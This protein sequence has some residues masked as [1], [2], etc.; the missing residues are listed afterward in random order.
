MSTHKKID[1]ICI[2]VIVIGVLLTL[3]VMNGEKIGIKEYVD[4]DAE[5]TVIDSAFTKNDETSE[6]TISDATY[7][8][9]DGDAATIKGDGAYILDGD[10]II[11]KEGKYV[12]SGNF[13]D[14]SVIIDSAKKAKVWVLLDDVSI[15]C[16]D[17]AAFIVEKADKVFI[18]L[19]KDSE[20]SITSGIDYSEKSVN[21]GIDGTIYA[22][23]DLTING[24]GKLFVKSEYKHGIVVKGDL[25]ITSGMISVDAAK[26]AIHI[27]D[28][29][30]M[31]NA[32]VLIEAGD[33]AI[34]ADKDVFIYSGTVLISKCYEGIE[35]RTVEISG[36]D[37]TIYPSDDGINASGEVV[38]TFPD[39]AGFL[40]GGGFPSGGAS[41]S[42]GEFPSGLGFPSDGEISFGGEIPFDGQFPDDMQ[43]PPAG[44]IPN[45][46]GSKSYNRFSPENEFKPDDISKD[47][48]KDSKKEDNKNKDNKNND[49]KNKEESDS[50]FP[51]VRIN[52]GTIKIINTQGVDADGI[53]SNG[54]II[55]SGGDVFI[56]LNGTGPNN[57]LDYGSENNGK[58]EITGGKVVAIGGS[59]MAEGFSETST[60]V[61]IVKTFSETVK[62]DSTLTI[63]DEDGTVYF[64]DKI[65]CGFSALSFSCSDLKIGSKLFVLVNGSGESI[66]LDGI[67]NQNINKGFGH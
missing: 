24:E 13:S 14:G 42:D 3:L 49:N 12:L 18:N 67:V 26:D 30:K 63:Q 35:A 11:A 23:D 25:A 54:D 8:N 38:R 65:P 33:D 48:E 10:L 16:N 47:K 34:T 58:L 31:E 51:T 2:A 52:G 36:G 27:N 15:N 22:K 9:L 62:K 5:G 53:D 57:A 64:E 6:M 55:I 1:L 43:T 40:S 17:N 20:N 44:V 21:K 61:S 28:Q 41:P 29:F 37:I 66:S 7:I 56:C 45:E 60:Q 46:N 39:D 32:E 19:T 4:E 50:I 59:S